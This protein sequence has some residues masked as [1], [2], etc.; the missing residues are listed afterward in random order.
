MLSKLSLKR[1][2]NKAK[3]LGKPVTISNK[4]L[5]AIYIVSPNGFV[6]TVIA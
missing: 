3:K 6:M 5:G 1:A 2:T 4:T